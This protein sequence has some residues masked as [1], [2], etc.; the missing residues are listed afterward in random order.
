M[1][2]RDADLV[3]SIANAPGVPE[4]LGVEAFDFTEALKLDSNIFLTAPGAVGIFEWS[5][6]RIYQGHLIFSP[7][8]KGRRAVRAAEQMRDF[9]F[10]NHADMLWGQPPVHLEGARKLLR[11]I[12]FAPEGFGSHPLVGDVEYLSCRR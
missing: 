2:T 12:G 9:M 3:N 10:T 6:P 11:M 5:A 8:C 7:S 1:R 4:M